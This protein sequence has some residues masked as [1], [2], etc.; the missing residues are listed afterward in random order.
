MKLTEK[1]ARAKDQFVSAVEALMRDLSAEE[2]GR[3]ADFVGE[4]GPVDH[5]DLGDLLDGVVVEC[6][7]IIVDARGRRP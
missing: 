7:N 1:E 4:Y 2:V 3:I 6:L 5:Q